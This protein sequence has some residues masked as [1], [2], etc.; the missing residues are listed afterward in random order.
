[1]CLTSVGGGDS[2][3][4]DAVCD[5]GQHAEGKYQWQRNDAVVPHSPHQSLRNRTQRSTDHYRAQVVTLWQK[6]T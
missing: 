5:G 3:G 6:T 1:M 2:L 4:E